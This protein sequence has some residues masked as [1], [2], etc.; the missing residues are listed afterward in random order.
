M[1][2]NSQVLQDIRSCKCT[3]A[4]VLPATGPSF[5]P[6]S[7]PGVEVVVSRAVVVESHSDQ[8]QQG[9]Q[10]EAKHPNPALLARVEVAHRQ[11]SFSLLLALL[12]QTLLHFL[13]QVLKIL[14]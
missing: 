9:E 4:G 5:V 13:V 1:N 10:D 12:L 6:E 8:S 14:T 11:A 2:N 3:I 7:I